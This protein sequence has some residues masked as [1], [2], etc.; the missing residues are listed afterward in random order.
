LATAAQQKSLIFGK[1][2][3]FSCL[4]HSGVAVEIA[5]RTGKRSGKKKKEVQLSRRFSKRKEKAGRYSKREEKTIA[6]SKKNQ[7]FSSA[8]N[9]YLGVGW[10]VAGIAASRAISPSRLKGRK[11]LSLLSL[12]LRGS[13]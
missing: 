2:G 10:G 3:A 9:K 8:F 7:D 4:G 13:Q 6:F 5:Q 1:S 12:G 11:L